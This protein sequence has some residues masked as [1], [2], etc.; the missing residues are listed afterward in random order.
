MIYRI[1]KTPPHYRTKNEWC[2]YPTY[3]FCHP[4]SDALEGIGFSLCSEEFFAHRELYNWLLDEL[5]LPR[6]QQREFPRL[7][8]PN[9]I[10]SKRGFR[11]LEDVLIG[12]DD[13]RLLTI[14]GLRRRGFNAEIL[15][16]FVS[17]PTNESK[18]DNL[19]KIA[20]KSLKIQANDVFLINP[21][22]CVVSNFEDYKKQISSVIGD[23][24]TKSVEEGA[25]IFEKESKTLRLTGEFFISEFDYQNISDEKNKFYLTNNN[26]T[27]LKQLPIPTVMKV[28]DIKVQNVANCI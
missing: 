25:V 17:S 10:T 12:F 28:E 8:F 3:D 20:R 23:D 4:I 15:R 26:T 1:C 24:D 9:N 5:N 22:M 6:S 11:Q 27:L 19:Y 7:S 21:I 2:I 13:P 18:I 14:A 16:D